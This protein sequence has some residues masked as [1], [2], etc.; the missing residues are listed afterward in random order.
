MTRHQRLSLH[1]LLLFLPSPLI[2]V[3]VGQAMVHVNPSPLYSTLTSVTPPCAARTGA[4]L[5]AKLLRVL[6]FDVKR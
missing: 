6:T 1:Y 2:V 4:I 5:V 3:C